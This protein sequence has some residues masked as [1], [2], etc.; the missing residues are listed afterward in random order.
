MTDIAICQVCSTRPASGGNIR[1]VDGV[2]V[3]TLHCDECQHLVPRGHA[4]W[5]TGMLRPGKSA[6][7]LGWVLLVIAVLAVV[8]VFLLGRGGT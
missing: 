4:S 7:G 5:S 6:P 8:F 1:R 3:Q 2:D